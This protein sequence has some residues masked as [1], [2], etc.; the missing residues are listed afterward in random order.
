MRVGFREHRPCRI[1]DDSRASVHSGA[2]RRAPRQRPL[3]S[4]VRRCDRELYE[5]IRG[6]SFRALWKAAESIAQT[7][8]FG[9]NTVVNGVTLGGL[10]RVASFAEAV[11][12]RELLLLP[13]VTT[14]RASG[15]D[16]ATGERLA[17]WINS[18]SSTIR[19]SLSANAASTNLP[20]AYA[21]R[22]ADPL[23]SFAH[24]SADG[25]LQRSSHKP[26]GVEIRAGVLGAL[27]DL[28]A[29]NGSA[30]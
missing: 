25:R 19:L 15:I 8:P 18:R 6:R 1:H 27:H 14:D 13:E 7:A 22:D 2:A 20:I 10:D 21:F 11:G 26:A 4:L 23:V 9:I 30:V 17:D 28:R 24:I 3:H 5:T 12:A 16:P 29:T